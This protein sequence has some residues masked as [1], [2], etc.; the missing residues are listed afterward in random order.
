MAITKKDV[1]HAAK[2]ARLALSQEETELYASQ[3]AKILTH[4]E[5]LG[6]LD[7]KGVEPTAYT[8][9]PKTM[10]RKDEAKQ[11]LPQDEILSNAPEKAKGCFKV[12]RIIE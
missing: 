11:S 10:F 12:P 1:E 5:K 7:T 9:S 4:V 3:M 6:A 8:M 2:L